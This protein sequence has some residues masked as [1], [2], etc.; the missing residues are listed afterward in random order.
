MYAPAILLI[1][2]VLFSHAN[3]SQAQE[4]NATT[5][6]NNALSS[7]PAVQRQRTEV[8]RKKKCTPFRIPSKGNGGTHV[9][10]RDVDETVVVTFP[11]TPRVVDSIVLE[12]RNLRIDQGRMSGLPA[13]PRVYR[14]FY[15]N[16]ADSATVS[17]SLTLSVTGTQGHTVTKTRG[18]STTKGASTTFT[19]SYSYAGASAGN[20]TTFNISR[21]VSLSSSE[22]ESDSKSETRSQ[23]WTVSVP[24]KKM[25]FVEML[26]YQTTVDIPF[27]AQLIVDGSL[28][29]NISGVRKATDLLKED[30]RI[31]PFEGVLR[32]T[33]VS[34]S[35][36]RTENLPGSPSCDSAE[37]G[38]LLMEGQ[39]H[40]LPSSSRVAGRFRAAEIFADAFGPAREFRT[41]AAAPSLDPNAAGP[42]V[43]EIGP[44]DGVSYEVI[45]VQPVMRSAPECGFNDLGI[46]KMANYNSEARRYRHHLN[47]TLINQWEETV[48][49]FVSCYNP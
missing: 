20:S 25:G 1:A 5:F 10:C 31:L 2:I 16:C 45:Y 44:A 15:K 13:E 29:P 4:Q 49:T 8:V 30:E 35:Q 37:A 42:R 36:F 18:V 38:N 48:F 33:N 23:T 26:A 17:T 43:S 3:V 40:N 7:K 22:S 41:T 32:L 47:G 6:L 46:P 21:T 24:P 11:D 28:E 34:E 9:D 27:S 19:G 14:A 39:A 12:V